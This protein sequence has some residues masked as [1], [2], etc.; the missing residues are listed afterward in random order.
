MKATSQLSP[1]QSHYV[2]SRLIEDRKVSSRDIVQY[3]SSMQ[4]EIRALENRLEHLR[5]LTRG[6]ASPA[7]RRG[8]KP[9]RAAK[10]AKA[11]KPAKRKVVLSPQQRASRQLQ[12]VYMSLIRQVPKAKRT[13]FQNLAREKGR[14]AAVDQ[15]KAE[16][17]KRK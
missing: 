2:L 15:I 14:Q 3:L 13:V 7:V 10:A 16:L 17:A 12:G 5:S 1:A 11:A 4:N 6:A 9:G 8:R